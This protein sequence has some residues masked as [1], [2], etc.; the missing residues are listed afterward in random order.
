[1][2]IDTAGGVLEAPGYT[3]ENLPPGATTQPSV[4]KP[5]TSISTQQGANI[6]AQTQQ[7]VANMSAPPA[8]APVS[9]A[10]YGKTVNG[11]KV[12]TPTFTGVNANVQDSQK[13][14]NYQ[15]TT[16]TTTSTPTKINLINPA[17]GQTMSFTDPD[18]NK[19][20]I[21]SYLNSGYDV[22]DAEG[23]VPSWLSPSGVQ[24]DPE[25][26]QAKTDLASA[27]T[28]LDA[29]KTTLANINVTNDPDMQSLLDS[30]G[31]Q[32][33]ARISA[34]QD[35]VNAQEA[36]ITTNGLR[37]GSQWTG[38]L[39]GITGSLISAEEKASL[40]NISS[41]QMQKTQALLKAKQSFQNN[42]FTQYSKFV[43]TAQSA[44]D[45][46]FS[47]LET[48]QKAQQK[49]DT[50][51]TTQNMNL[52]ISK[53]YAGGTTDA[54]DILTQ[55]QKDGYTTTLKDVGSAITALNPKASSTDDFK[56][57]QPQ[58]SQLLSAGLSPAQIQALHDY[59]NGKGDGSA[60]TGLT[61]DQQ[62]AV[63][64]V[65]NGTASKIAGSA[66]PT[67]A[68]LNPKDKAGSAA[69][70]YKSGGLTYAGSDITDGVT[71]LTASKNSGSEADGKY[72]D[73]NVYLQ[74][75]QAWSKGGGSVKDFIKNYP[76]STWI[77]PA[78]TNVTPA[79]NALIKQDA[80]AVST[81][82]GRSL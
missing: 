16:E 69:K 11:S 3:A 80:A 71:K 49:Q 34:A 23:D 29:A 20:T 21:Q 73:P 82:G 24:S 32:W 60:I 36:A 2:S 43:T 44:Y 17:T 42:Q 22:S 64:D 51:I 65:L 40:K 63:H 28:T 15:P 79:I 45:K 46:Q 76:I 8:P 27:K 61:T 39:G 78:N 1:M 47:E 50:A 70:T 5:V 33:D 19:T 4:A 54:G 77:N 12:M 68:E 59:Y 35:T 37:T 13:G 67:Y 9:D 57:S 55:L 31:S 6:V 14:T 52:D 38:G 18:N 81:K 48:L 30:I 74:M 26:E 10:D 41:L 56:F 62:T 58:N 7:Q 72:A 53:L 75:A 25:V 66:V